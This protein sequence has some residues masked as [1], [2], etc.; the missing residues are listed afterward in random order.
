MASPTEIARLAAMANMLR[1]D[2][3]APSIQTWLAATHTTRPYRDLAVALAWVAADPASRTPKRM[4]EAGPWWAATAGDDHTTP[5]PPRL[6]QTC[7]RVHDPDRPDEHPRPTATWDDAGRPVGAH[8][9]RAALQT[10][11]TP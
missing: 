5:T 9:A 3:P 4:D 6:C 11:D 2:W 10:E 7:R 8:L 1:P